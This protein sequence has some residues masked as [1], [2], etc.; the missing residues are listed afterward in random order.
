MTI[1][2]LVILLALGCA[3]SW[4]LTSSVRRY[5]LHA[6]LL[7]RP[8]A[9]SSHTVP[10]PRGGGIAIVVSYLA[11]IAA[12]VLAHAM[13]E[14]LAA[15]LIGS[16][17]LVAMLGFIDDRKPLPARWRF[18]GHLLAAGWVIAWLG[19]L[20]AVPV[21]GA[22]VDLGIGAVL[23][24]ALYLVWSI[25]LFNFMDG[26]DG[27]ASLEA[28]TV[29]LSGAL[30]WWLTQPAGDW[31]AAVLFASCVAG[32]LIWNFPPARIFM[33][34]AGSGFLGCTIATL[35]LWS[36]HTAPH[37]FWSWFI[38]VG[39]FMADATV[40]LVRRVRRGDRFNEAHRSHAYQYAARRYC[41]HKVVSMTFVAIT[42]LW[43]VPLAVAVAL[44]RLDGLTGVAIAYVPLI[45]L[46]FR[47]KAGD[48][49]AQ[50]V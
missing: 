11:L 33:G 49:A 47:F 30:V 3:A 19:P 31:L 23:L 14:R 10:T 29:A 17:A 12:L 22:S 15:A 37:L 32:F 38:L 16:G 50:E 7:D 36:S 27:I 46:A 45:V 43:L 6:D 40:T 41:S 44:G 39:C 9:R 34:D 2:D 18:L 25:N 20:P 21:F 42:A 4:A 13:D 5:A 28:I 8:N 24:S 35:A 48:R 1:A 26:I